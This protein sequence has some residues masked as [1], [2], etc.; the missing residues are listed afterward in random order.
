MNRIIGLFLAF[1]C[2]FVAV[3]VDSS[4]TILSRLSAVESSSAEGKNTLEY[5]KALD[6][7]IDNLLGIGEAKTATTL[8]S[9]FLKSWQQRWGFGDTYAFFAMRMGGVLLERGMLPLSKSWLELVLRMK[10]DSISPVTV[11]RAKLLMADMFIRRGELKSA[12]HYLYEAEQWFTENHK[13]RQLYD[14]YGLKYKIAMSYYDFDAAANDA[15]RQMQIA[16]SVF[17]VDSEPYRAAALNLMEYSY[18]LDNDDETDAVFESLASRYIGGDAPSDN[19]SVKAYDENMVRFFDNIITMISIEC[20]DAGED[21]SRNETLKHLYNILQARFLDILKIYGPNSPVS[22]KYAYQIASLA[23]MLNRYAVAE[24]LMDRIRK[25][26]SI[27]MGG[28][29][30]ETLADMAIVKLYSGKRDESITYFHQALKMYRT[31]IMENMGQM[32]AA[33]RSSYWQS[34]YNMYGRILMAC[35]ET[36]ENEGDFMAIGYDVLLLTKGLLLNSEIELERLVNKSGNRAMIEKYIRLRELRKDIALISQSVQNHADAEPKI[37]DLKRQTSELEHELLAEFPIMGDHTAHFSIDRTKICGKLKP[38]EIAVEFAEITPPDMIGDKIYCAFALS[39]DGHVRMFDLGRLTEYSGNQGNYMRYDLQ[40]LYSSVWEPILS[41]YP[42]VNIVYFSAAGVLNKLPLESADASSDKVYCRLSSTR[43]IAYTH[44][45]GK[46]LTAAGFGGL[47]YDA[48]A[49]VGGNVRDNDMF[50]ALGRRSGFEPLPETKIEIETVGNQLKSKGIDMD[51]FTADRGTEPAF[52]ALDGKTYDI[53]H[54]AT[55]GFFLSLT[56]AQKI[57]PPFLIPASECVFE[58]DA[59][60]TRSGLLFSGANAAFGDSGRASGDDGIMTAY[61]I[62]RLNFSSL[63]LAV[64]SACETGL[65]DISPEGV[66]GLQRA[67][68]KAGAR[69]ILMTLWKVDDHAAQMLMNKFYEN[70]LNGKSLRLSLTEAQKYLRDYE[71]DIPADDYESMSPSQRRARQRQ[72]SD[73][74]SNQSPS[75][76][77]STQTY[78]P[79]AHPKHWSGFILLD[80][81]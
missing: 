2:T 76:A 8:L 70:M 44:K 20:T 40:H 43:E 78:K 57:S 9:E 6:T 38:G 18:G 1:C 74:A 29:K 27:L 59:R 50:K 11:N 60:L 10:D 37:K 56:Q 12:E 65:G 51:M 53:L 73:Q 66:Y 77:T 35:L 79:Y 48:G 36:G 54:I 41:N 67:F 33:E 72:S 3:A 39:A 63:D 7:E 13:D 28:N 80:A 81:L 5:C 15:R 31:E 22:L 17:G 24:T 21:V 49:E 68:K 52:R 25:V 58:E 69:T 64:L 4:D 62:S 61:E 45:S 30:P 46:M 71:V 55:H 42:E 19:V 34:A 16:A 32:T 47:D 26:E 14:V 23:C 75:T